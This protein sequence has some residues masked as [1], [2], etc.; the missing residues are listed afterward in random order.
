LPSDSSLLEELREMDSSVD[1][2][3]DPWDR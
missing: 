3:T 1:E 2:L